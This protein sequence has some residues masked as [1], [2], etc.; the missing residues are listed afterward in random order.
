MTEPGLKKVKRTS[1]NLCEPTY[2]HVF[3][4]FSL[5][6]FKDVDNTTFFSNVSSLAI[7]LNIEK[8][9]FWGKK[10]KTRHTILSLK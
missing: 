10:L 9:Y 7:S 3:I 6:I 1:D 5:E 8:K 2:M 4:N